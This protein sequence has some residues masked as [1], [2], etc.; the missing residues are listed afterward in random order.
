MSL[1]KPQIHICDDWLLFSFVDLMQ[2]HAAAKAIGVMSDWLEIVPAIDSLAVQFDP[3]SMSP[4]QAAIIFSRQLQN[5]SCELNVDQKE[6]CLP[7]CYDA[8]H[9]P[10]RD[11]LAER[12]G[13]PAVDLADW[14]SALKFS[15]AM[16]GFMPGF[17][18][19]QTDDI[20]PLIGRLSSPRQRV[21]AGSVGIIGSQNC[22]YSFESPGGW[23]LIGRTPVN[24]FD[25][26]SEE[27]ALVSAGQRIK[28]QPITATEFDAICNGRKR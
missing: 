18:Y 12:L 28:F 21:A 19:L 5:I 9:A 24:L 15:V 27:P 6:I 2:V 26:K 17:A 3:A 4:D 14:H 13:L 1:A 11:W 7:V 20:I 10:D 16:L 23:P 25:P 22:L 8:E